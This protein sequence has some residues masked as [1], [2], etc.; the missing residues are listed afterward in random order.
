[1]LAKNIAPIHGLSSL[2]NHRSEVDTN[3]C[4]TQR[5]TLDPWKSTRTGV[6]GL[7]AFSGALRGLKL[8]P[9][10]WRHLVPRRWIEPVETASGHPL[11]PCQG[12]SQ[13]CYANV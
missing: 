3:R 2:P 12:A 5:A 13:E 10:K 11:R 6:V 4:L 1:M 8:V 7:C 9:S